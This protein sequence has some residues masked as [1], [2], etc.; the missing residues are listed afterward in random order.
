[1]PP[2]TPPNDTKGREKR[3]QISWPRRS[4]NIPA[5]K[6]GRRLQKWQ[7][8]WQGYVYAPLCSLSNVLTTPRICC[9]TFLSIRMYR[10]VILTICLLQEG[11]NRP[12]CS[13]G[14]G[15]SSMSDQGPLVN[16]TNLWYKTGRSGCVWEQYDA[17]EPPSLPRS[18]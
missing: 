7:R 10:Y 4:S 15:S 3:F 13:G 11:S 17:L 9:T 2:R 1:M 16:P 18:A 8:K 14:P 6:P 12:D 5:L